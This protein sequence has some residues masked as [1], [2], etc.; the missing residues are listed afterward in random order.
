M[1]TG[2]GSRQ[3]AVGRRQKAES[4]KQGGAYLFGSGRYASGTSGR[5]ASVFYRG[6]VRR[7][8]ALRKNG[9]DIRL[10]MNAKASIISEILEVMLAE[11]VS[12]LL[13]NIIF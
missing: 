10:G 3:W 7:E 5:Y 11:F 1:R 6:N 13:M 4:R 12:F 2:E 9:A 8:V